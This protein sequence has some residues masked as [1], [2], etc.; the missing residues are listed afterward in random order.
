MIQ[1][2]IPQSVHTRFELKAST[3]KLQKLCEVGIEYQTDYSTWPFAT[4]EATQADIRQLN[5]KLA[6]YAVPITAL[7][8]KP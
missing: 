5:I 6:L 8:Y 1:S 4:I 3:V 2:T 7:K